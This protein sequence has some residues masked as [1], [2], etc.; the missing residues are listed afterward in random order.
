MN[1][2]LK[3]WEEGEVVDFLN[4][5]WGD[6]EV[7]GLLYPSGC[8]LAELDPTAFRCCVADMPET[9]VCE[10]CGQEYGEEEEEAEE[11]CKDGEV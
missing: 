11:C 10:E 4:E 7:C 6:V 1:A 2:Y 9:W 3:E 8:A 5:V